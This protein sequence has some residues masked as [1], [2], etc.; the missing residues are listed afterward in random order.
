MMLR[1]SAK[2][3]D[4]RQYAV[5]QRVS[6]E[7]QDQDRERHARPGKRQDAKDNR[8]DSAETDHP[9]V[10][11]QLIDNHQ[12]ANLLRQCR[13]QCSCRVHGPALPQYTFR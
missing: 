13:S 10:S 12:P 6:A 2:C 9:P 7:Q 1:V 5:Y 4:H 8:G 11:R 3:G